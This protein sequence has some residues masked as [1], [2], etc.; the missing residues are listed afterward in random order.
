MTALGSRN[1]LRELKYKFCFSKMAVQ[2][3]SK[4]VYSLRSILNVAFLSRRMQRISN[5]VGSFALN[6]NWP[7]ETGAP[8][9]GWPRSEV[10]L[11]GFDWGDLNNSNSVY[12][13]QHGRSKE[14]CPEKSCPASQGHPTPLANKFTVSPV[15]GSLR[16]IRKCMNNWLTQGGLG[17]WNNFSPYKWGLRSPRPMETRFYPAIVSENC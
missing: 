3:C 6:S 12:K 13:V 9:A 7:R 4:T 15:N 1:F 5:N 8:P 11:L 2:G 10:G 16:F 14:N 17:P